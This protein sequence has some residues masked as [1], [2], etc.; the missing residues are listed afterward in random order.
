MRNNLVNIILL[1]LFIL[2]PQG[3]SAQDTNEYTVSVAVGGGYSYYLTEINTSGLNVHSFA[4]NIKAFWEPEHLLSAGIET[5]FYPMSNLKRNK[6]FTRYGITNL[7]TSLSAYPIMIFFS[8]K[9]IDELRLNGSLGGVILSSYMDSFG[10][11]LRST[12][13]STSFG[14]GTSYDI[15][16]SNDFT[17]QTETRWIGISK[18]KDDLLSVQL[19]IKYS[20]L[21][22]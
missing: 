14:L 8:M 4:F 3:I 21:N 18:T 15:P 16:I 9:I 1:P 5:G 22:Y 17:I 19:S 10:N 13:W 20:I 6:V 7:N 11:E 2:L 12:A